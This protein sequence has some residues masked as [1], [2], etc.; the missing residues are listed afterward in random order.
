MKDSRSGPLDLAGSR[1][2][3]TP[4]VL[5]LQSGELRVVAQVRS[6]R[7]RSAEPVRSAACR[8]RQLMLMQP[9][10]HGR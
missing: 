8:A 10:R 1:I 6:R 4:L 2:L 7:T 3:A 5:D 9:G